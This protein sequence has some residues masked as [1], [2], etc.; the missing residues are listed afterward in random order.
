MFSTVI[1]DSLNKPFNKLRT[2]GKVLIP[3]VVSLSN[4]ERNQLVQ[5]FLNYVG[6]VSAS[7]TQHSQRIVGLRYT[8]PTYILLLCLV[9]TINGC[10]SDPFLSTDEPTKETAEPTTVAAYSKSTFGLYDISTFD[11]YVD[12]D[13]IHLIAGGKGSV[14]DKPVTLRYTRSEDGGRNW[15]APVILAK[16]PVS[17]NSRGND[18]QL[19]AQGSHLLAAWQGKG[20]LPGMGPMVSAYSQDNGNT[21]AKG[22]NPAINNTGDQSHTDLIADQ[23][24]HFHAV[25]LEDP[26]ENGY[27]SLRYA[28]SVDGG[29]QWNKAATLDGSTCSCC[30]NTFALS[31]KNELNILYRD[32]KPRDMS[33]LR[34]SDEGKAWQQVG[35][36]GKFGWQF[37]GCPHVG[38]GLTYTGT[39]KPQQL[40]SV[41]W[42][43][44]EQKA[45]LYYLNSGDNGKSWSSPRKLGD[46][47]IH[48][49]IAVLDGKLI[50]IWDEME[51]DG[52]SIFYA[53][54]EDG[55]LTWFT[56]VRLTAAK[57]AATHPR[58][59][60]TK[61]G[62]LAMWTEKPNKQPSQL[63]W[64][65]I[66]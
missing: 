11:V 59:V 46:A 66:E 7:V 29:K 19:A 17:I 6:W 18:I 2:N 35:T 60:V 4:H 65:L 47:A 42:T 27:Q 9:T 13:I 62:F 25:W 31:P 39:D 43:G 52:T 50:A 20:E 38:G 41:V 48:G 49:D 33:L 58:L 14:N 55:G 61:A 3:F 16:F 32:M 63:A 12:N 15:L 40:H 26:E 37:D 54:S 53:K 28:R 57:N 5:S 34:T 24:G 22:T 51:A 21:W 64:Q 8:N 44:L 23:H 36:V 30:W 10:S 56:A 45:G 1:K